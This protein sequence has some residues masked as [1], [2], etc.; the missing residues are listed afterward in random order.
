MRRAP[1]TGGERAARR[2]TI[3]DVADAARV[4]V[5]TVSRALNGHDNVAAP[6][7]QRVQEAAAR[8]RY[9]PHA[10]AR[11]LSSRRTHTIGVVL[12]ALH[13]EFFSQLVRGIDRAAREHGQHLLVSSYHD[14]PDAQARALRAMR[15]RVD[16]MLMM[17]AFGA[18]PVAGELLAEL[19]AVL[20]NPQRPVRDVVALGIDNHGGAVAMVEHLVGRGHRRIA[21]LEGA[22]AC[23]DAFERRRG[24]RDAIARL[25]PGTPEWII[26]GAG[27]EASGHEA[28]RQLLQAPQLPDAVFATNDV[29]ALGCL[30]AFAQAGLEVP[31]RVAVA[32][33]D[34]IPLARFQNPALT[35]VRVDLAALSAQAVQLLLAQI[36]PDG[37]SPPPEPVGLLQPQLVVR[38]S[39]AR[40][41]TRLQVAGN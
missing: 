16:G 11:S 38:D 4:S 10:A 39:C 30:C 28:G 31:G 17:S 41:A 2:A 3:R 33:F 20:I 37:V 24:Y 40:P 35:T 14:D 32:G 29:A 13:C 22:D 6:V 1:G 12:P 15:G 9:I 26:A 7:R 25:L 36:E 23:F 18:V 21:F 5:A 34:D 19:P 8:L 27:D